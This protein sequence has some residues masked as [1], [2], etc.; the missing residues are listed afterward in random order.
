MKHLSAEEVG[1]IASIIRDW[2]LP[3]IRWEAVCRE[4][5]LQ[6]GRKYT[7]RSLRDKAEIRAAFQ[8]AK[9]FRA[10]QK[11]R[12]SRLNPDDRIA[13]LQA[14][15]NSLK[16]ILAEYDLR[17]LRHIDALAG[18]QSASTGAPILPKDLEHPLHQELPRLPSRGRA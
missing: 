11:E 10:S 17:F 5:E 3:S 4:V 6:V 2:D 14:E 15:V 9:Q 16:A 13:S 7:A 18:F 8:L 1:K 12:R